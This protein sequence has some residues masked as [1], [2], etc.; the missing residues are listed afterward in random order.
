MNRKRLIIISIIAV[1]IIGSSLLYYVD[2]GLANNI[3]TNEIPQNSKVIQYKGNMKTTI[4]FATKEEIIEYF[5]EKETLTYEEAEKL[6]EKEREINSSGYD[7]EIRTAILQTTFFYDSIGIRFNALVRYIYSLEE[8]RPISI[9]YVGNVYTDTVGEVKLLEF[10]STEP[11]RIYYNYNRLEVSHFGKPVI[12]VNKNIAGTLI[13]EHNF[14]KLPGGDFN[15][16][17]KMLE[18]E[19]PIL[20]MIDVTLEDLIWYK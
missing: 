16:W 20:L 6:Y 12:E 19:E 13:N 10:K 9:D 5:M 11:P 4:R 18:P 7:E 8:N 14:I 3:E 2:A 15:I 17:T 1:C